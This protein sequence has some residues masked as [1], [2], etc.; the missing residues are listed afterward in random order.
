MI[1][2]FAIVPYQP[3]FLNEAVED[4]TR[5]YGGGH[6]IDD[7]IG[8]KIAQIPI[9]RHWTYDNTIE[10][11]GLLGEI[12]FQIKEQ[13]RRD[14]QNYCE[15]QT[16]IGKQILPKFPSEE[17]TKF[18]EELARGERRDIN[19]LTIYE[20][21]AWRSRQLQHNAP[22]LGETT[23]DTKKIK[24]YRQCQIEE[25]PPSSSNNFGWQDQGYCGY[26]QPQVRRQ[27][28][29]QEPVRALT[30][31]DTLD[32]YLIPQDRSMV[33]YPHSMPQP[34]TYQ[35]SSP[36]EDY[37]TLERSQATQWTSN[38]LSYPQEGVLQTF[39]GEARPTPNYEIPKS[40][41]QGG[42]RPAGPNQKPSWQ[43]PQNEQ[44]SQDK[45]PT[46]PGMLCVFCKQQ[47]HWIWTCKRFI[48]TPIAERFEFA[49][50]ERL[51][52]HCLCKGHGV[53][54]CKYNPDRLCGVD[55]C[56]SRHH[57]LVHV[58]RG[59][60][61]IS[62]EEF[63]ALYPPDLTEEERL[64]Q[65]CGVN[66][67]TG[68]IY[69]MAEGESQEAFNA[70]K[71][72]MELE[73]V[74]IKTCTAE[75]IYP[76][77]RRRVVIAM[78][79]GANNTNID[80]DL[81]QELDLP[82]FKKDIPREIH[83]V[84]GKHSMLSNYVQFQLCPVGTTHGPTYTVG[85]F[86]MKGLMEDAPT[87]D[88]LYAST[89]YEYLKATNPKPPA[90]EDRVCIL[91]GTDFASLM[92]STE[93][94]CGGHLDPVAE[95][96]P[97][98]WAYQGRT[99]E[100]CFREA[101]NLNFHTSFLTFNR[102]LM[103]IQKPESASTPQDKFSVGNQPEKESQRCALSKNTKTIKPMRPLSTSARGSVRLVVIEE[104]CPEDSIDWKE[105]QQEY[106][107]EVCEAFLTP[108]PRQS[109]EI[110]S[111]VERTSVLGYS[112][113]LSHI[114][115]NAIEMQVQ[116]EN[117]E[118]DFIPWLMIS[119][120]Q[121]DNESVLEQEQQ[122]LCQKTLANIVA[123]SEEDLGEETEN[124]ERIRE[125]QE[126][127]RL[128][129]YQWEMDAVGLAEKKP[130][131]AANSEPTQD[132][133]TPAQRAIDERMRIIYLPEEGRFQMTIPW[134]DGEKP[135]FRCNRIPVLRR[136]AD[137]IAKLP[138]ERKE[139]VDA[140]F[141]GYLE[142][143]YI[144][145]LTHAE[146]FEQDCRY[147]PF[148][149]VCDESKETTPMRIVWDC[150]AVF[151][152]KSLNSEIED[153][154][155]RLQD[156]F[157]VLMRLRRFEFTITS[158]VSE[159]FL[160]VRLDPKDRRYHRFIYDRQDYEWNSILFGNVASP[161]GSQK[162]LA[163]VCDMFGKD[164]PEAEETL[165]HSLY[166][167]DASDSRPT[168]EKAVQLAQQ[169]IQLL[170]KCS[171][172]IHKFY[173]NSKLVLENL[174]PKLLAKQIHIGD[175]EFEIESGKILGMCYNASPDEDYLSF[176]GK[177]KNIREWTNKSQKTV[178]EQGKWT[179]RFVARAAASIYD[180]H[181]LIAPFTV[182]SKI[183]LQ[184]IWKR[185]E[186][187]WDDIMPR[188]LCDRWE[189]WM[190]QVFVIPE[191]K[192]PRWANF[193]PKAKYQ[194]HTF[195]DASED[196]MCCAV[197]LRVKKR[198]QVYMTLLAAKARV[199]PLK[200][201]SISRLELAACV[202]GI[203]LASAARDIYPT[204]EE[205]TFF[206][207]DSMVC[208]HWINTPAKAFKA[209]V[210]HRIG[211]IQTHTEPRQ[212]IHVPT[213]ENPADIGTRPI[214]AL[215]LK[216]KTLWWEGPEFLKLPPQEWP[217]RSIIQEVDDKELKQTNFKF[218]KSEKATPMRVL[219]L[220][221]TRGC[222]L[223]DPERQSVGTLWNGL[224]RIIRRL[225]YV[226]RFARACRKGHRPKTKAA[227]LGE[228][229][230][231]KIYLVRL[232]QKQTFRDELKLLHT[233][234]DEEMTTLYQ[235]PIMRRSDIRRFTPV[236]DKSGVIRSRSR[237]DKSNYYGWEK[238]HP[239][240]LSQNCALA[241]LIV[242]EAHYQVGHPV[243]HNAVKARISSRYII[244]GLGSMIR[245][246][247]RACA[248]CEANNN[249]PLDQMQAS[250]PTTRLGER[251]RAFADIG[252]D[253]AGPFD[254][255]QGRGKPRKK[256]WVLVLTCLAVRAV[257]L[258][259]TGG[260]ET[261]HV[262]NAISRFVD[263]RGV[264]KTITC[265]NQTS[266]VKADKDLREWNEQLD[267][268][269][270]QRATQNYR[271]R[272][273]IEWIFNPPHAPHFGGVYE[274]MVKA[275]KRALYSTV[276]GADLDEEEFRTTI[277]KVAWMLNQRPIQKVGDPTDLETLTPEH[278]LGGCPED[279]VFPPDM[280]VGRID[281]QV[282]LKYQ[283]E[284]Q[285]HFW[286]R[287]QEEIIPTLAARSKW[288]FNKENVRVDD[289]MVEVDPNLGRGKWKKVRITKV[290]PSDD[291]KIRKVEI[292]D[293]ERRTYI[294]PIS[295]LVPIRL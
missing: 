269:Q 150:R 148:F 295:R 34:Q 115:E 11:L 102:N 181:G 240:I 49:R 58:P 139:K 293:G 178:I 243:G 16:W 87:A 175:G 291:G 72:W 268:E 29:F 109:M 1:R 6:R 206:W 220:K 93:T 68:Q 151:Y 71:E 79:S 263:V 24:S 184:E 147:L 225:I 249:K 39:A 221:P 14:Y 168:E 187:G 213:K 73:N 284:V 194:L 15:G 78:D 253:Y 81:A 244:S 256:I 209:F 288:L 223:I 55:G 142:K 133:W 195:C 215:E 163:T 136:Q 140:I 128:I 137:T 286:T 283:L 10:I 2:R 18:L 108:E 122:G 104:N 95:K 105:V 250:L 162:V 3:G 203:R 173:T 44:T 22:Y 164:F 201:E 111:Q 135:N 158:D 159:M 156:L 153:T 236:L 61:M 9:H 167:D 31:R 182:Q 48:A 174:D 106:I 192:V 260:M 101:S 26:E 179:K 176:A 202:M 40:N 210:A 76:G 211:E 285:K 270:L 91:L 222:N 103:E 160:R 123:N 25:M 154:P 17:R 266:F 267:F 4:L 265:D 262:L 261:T 5:A 216:E 149:F 145:P 252:M 264:P 292:I 199:S 245:T 277:S 190:E 198:R 185:S 231:A 37:Q 193:E 224:Q 276:R 207:T 12:L 279:A 138:P 84:H 96:T 271:E 166:M 204:T 197:Y 254:I 92:M 99:G 208:L 59:I 219:S 205:D 183:I 227:E 125:N 65:I 212:W 257:H 77:G 28:T 112:S 134:K 80:A 86:T 21:V 229:E 121:Q 233:F 281:L 66:I 54:D 235:H 278:F 180:P 130:R 131:T 165:R 36:Q 53:R 171:M 230:T 45:P 152:G 62:I 280:P 228:I 33:P 247:K 143:D 88:W 116:N 129:R 239:I 8:H 155:N 120:L 114:P 75:L 232:A 119:A 19:L 43:A 20:Y 246:L 287:F 32:S 60:N 41:Q 69:R 172:P 218:K 196:G 124:E 23:E 290:F 238:T 259:P 226:I 126:L 289:L 273:G 85:A 234:P 127:E 7:Y 272:Q 64:A 35:Q 117:P 191:F 74:S 161:N 57:P 113:T 90:R 144:R 255:K 141:T 217:R 47:D 52:Y 83:M 146:I 51:C 275:M 82:I 56:G 294:R 186:L 258:E 63:L 169:L 241:K 282:R 177:F 157:R 251:M 50:K 200:A 170:G 70:R 89:K 42:N 46:R 98:G 27:V 67:Q 274:I 38:T 237:L 242:Q 248:V 94:I 13:R 214:S 97:L 118:T 30:H 100:T 110:S 107:N 132:Q 188:E 189:E